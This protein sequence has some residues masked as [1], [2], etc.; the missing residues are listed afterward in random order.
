MK[1]VTTIAM[2]WMMA[3]GSAIAADYSAGIVGLG[4]ADCCNPNGSGTGVNLYTT[5]ERGIKL[6][7]G[8]PFVFQPTPANPS[9]YPAEP[10]AA[11]VSERFVY[12]AYDVFPNQPILVQFAIT[13]SGLQ[14]RWQQQ[15]STGDPDLGGS[16]LTTAG[17]YVME[18]LYPIGLWVRILNE[19]GQQLVIESNGLQVLNSSRMDANGKFYYSCRNPNADLQGANLPATSVSIYDLDAIEAEPSAPFF[20]STDPAYIQSVCAP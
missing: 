9:D 6:V 18:K 14:Y 3:G 5:T 2:M 11:V 17:R 4:A 8:S 12:V 20:T 19:A 15:I 1:V 13:P 10:V 16:T 7:K